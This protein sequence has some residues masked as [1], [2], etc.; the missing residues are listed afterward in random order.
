MNQNFD[1]MIFLTATTVTILTYS[2]FKD[3]REKK[4]CESGKEERDRIEEY[5]KIDVNNQYNKKIAEIKKR[6]TEMLDLTEEILKAAINH[7]KEVKKDIERKPRSLVECE[8][9]LSE[10]LERLKTIKGTTHD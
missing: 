4:Y 8:K 1:F 10:Y 2:Y 9:D 6:H 5:I 3:K 7:F